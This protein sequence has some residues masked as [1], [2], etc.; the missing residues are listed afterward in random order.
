MGRDSTNRN[1]M[2]TKERYVSV[3]IPAGID[4]GMNLRLAGKGAEGEPGGQNGNLFVQILVDDDPYFK[5]EGLDVHTEIPISFVQAVLGGTVD[6]KTLTGIVEMKVPKG[7]QMGTKLLLR[8]KGIPMLN[9]PSTNRKGNHIV[10]LQIKIPN[11]INHKQELLLRQFD[12]ESQLCGL[13]LSGRI[14]KAAGSAFESIFGSGKN[15]K[16]KNDKKKDSNKNQTQTTTTKNDD[17]VD[18]DDDKEDD[19]EEKKQQAQ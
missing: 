12:E 19:F 10:H 14:A 5:R 2:V 16:K 13:G 7:T 9:N 1:R 15:N 3:D 4:T 17:K 8:N 11:K 18:D 6:V